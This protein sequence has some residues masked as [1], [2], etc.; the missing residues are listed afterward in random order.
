MTIFSTT[1][2][3]VWFAWHCL[4]RNA[5]GEP[6]TLRS[7]ERAHGLTNGTLH[8]ALWDIAPRPG[9]QRAE[10]IASSLGVTT[11]WLY[12]GRG[13]GPSATWPIVPRPEREPKRR[14]KRRDEAVPP[15]SVMP[16]RRSELA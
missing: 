12:Y 11:D 13:A 15:S 2:H 7:L 10:Q 3:R 5:R 6:P 8:K 16:R 4:P 14:R 1:G 9:I